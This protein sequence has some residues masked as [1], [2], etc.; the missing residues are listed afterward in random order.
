MA[1]RSIKVFAIPDLHAP[2]TD[3]KSVAKIYAA[4]DNARPD[5]VV[6]LGDALDAF[7]FSRFARSHNIM[8]PE[9]E[10]EEGRAGL[11]R[12]W[13][14]VHKA[15]PKAKKI[16]LSGNHEA[17]LV[18]QTLE[19]FPEVYSLLTKIQGDFYKFK[20]VETIHDHR[21]E[22]VINGVIYCHGWLTRLGDHARYFLKPVV[23]GHTHRAGVI[24]FNLHDKP[25]FELDCG[26]LADKFQVPL[27]YGPTKTTLS[28]KGYGEVDGH[29]PRFVPL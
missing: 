8:T 1:K 5:Y 20:N 22:L 12:F 14:N 21:H 11:A 29:I 6:Q 18:R 7:S 10:I 15:A 26:Y 2:F 9:E 3:W 24:H 16:Q 27:Q 19:R 28:V 4:I 23:H 17:R 13:D 25:I